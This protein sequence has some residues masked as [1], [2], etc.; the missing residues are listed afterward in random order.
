MSAGKPQLQWLSNCPS[1]PICYFGCLSSEKEG[2][3]QAYL[4]SLLPVTK[5]NKSLEVTLQTEQYQRVTMVR[6]MRLLSYK[7][8]SRLLWL[9]P[10]EL[11]VQDWEVP[12]LRASRESGTAQW[13]YTEGQVTYLVFSEQPKT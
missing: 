10:Q 12:T 13:R 4:T 2:S 1:E 7:E 9:V 3:L 11:V 8:K 5:G 6:H